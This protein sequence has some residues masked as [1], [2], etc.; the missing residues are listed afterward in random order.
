[1]IFIGLALGIGARP[2]D[3]SGRCP[4]AAGSAC[5]IVLAGASVMLLAFASHLSMA[6]VGALL[7]GVGAGMAFLS[8]TTLLGGEVDDE[9]RGRVFAFVQI[10]TR[11]VLML[12]IALS[13]VLVGVGG[14]RQL[15]RSADLGISVSTTRLL[16]LAAGVVGVFAGISA[17]RPDGR[18]AGRAGPR[19]PL[20]LAPRAAR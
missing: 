5:S 4:G 17:F 15:D 9:V 20:G 11:V 10:G 1:M 2:D 13:S 6:V 8:G 14:S 18:Q 16:L 19:R 12:A 3:R 7:V